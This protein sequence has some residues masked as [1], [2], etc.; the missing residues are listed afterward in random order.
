MRDVADGVLIEKNGIGLLPGQR[1]V[2]HLRQLSV[3]SE[4]DGLYLVRQVWADRFPDEFGEPLGS[5]TLGLLVE[6]VSRYDLMPGGPG[7]I[8]GLCL[9]QLGTDRGLIFAHD[10]GDVAIRAFLPFLALHHGILLEVRVAVQVHEG[11]VGRQGSPQLYRRGGRRGQPERGQVE[12]AGDAFLEVLPGFGQL[13]DLLA[14]GVGIAAGMEQQAGQAQARQAKLVGKGGGVRVAARHQVA[15][16]AFLEARQ[17]STRL[18]EDII[19]RRC[20]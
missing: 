14:I 7:V 2:R 6:A 3:G 4:I 10:E 19:D 9:F 15:V 13:L 8:D 17:G 12:F 1:T 5:V 20:R 11:G 18:P 16:A